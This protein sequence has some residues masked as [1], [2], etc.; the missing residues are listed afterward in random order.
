MSTLVDTL[1]WLVGIPSATGSE[2]AICKGISERLAAH[3]VRVVQESVVIGEPS[4]EKVLLVG[5]IDTVPLQ[6]ETGARIDGGRLHGLGST[7][8]KGGLA[9]MIHLI[10][11]LGTDGIVG[12]FYAGEEGPILN[13][14]LGPILDTIPGLT[15]SR[16][17]IVL[18]PSNREL[19]AGCNGVIN[20]TLTFVG[21]PAHSARPW[22]GVNAVTRSGPFL[23]AMDGLEPEPRNVAGLVFQEVMSVT[24]AAG[25]VA[26]NV[27]PGRFEL[28][29]NYRFAPDRSIEDAERN[30]RAVCAPA[31]T[32]DI[33]DLA[34]AALPSVDNP[35]FVSLAEA[36]GAPVT[37]KQG[38]TDVAQ[39]AVRGVPAVNFGPGETDLAHKPGESVAIDD[40]QWAFDSLRQ[41]LS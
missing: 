24:K 15:S 20:A 14:Q 32:I 16:A 8:M 34:P 19:Q 23:T 6:G 38:W 5:H 13:N 25:G 26:N 9:V 1:A 22:L 21:E 30:L 4:E 41:V 18:E 12:I 28:N 2:A 11:A 27:I 17:G 29:I 40:L 7:D 10:E 36:S 31:D 37:P 35:L 33:T 3:P 39:L